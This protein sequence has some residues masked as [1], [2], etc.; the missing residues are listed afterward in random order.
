MSVEHLAYSMFHD[1]FFPPKTGEGNES[2]EFSL[3][4]LRKFTLAQSA[5]LADLTFVVFDFET[6][7]LDSENDKIIEIGALKIQGG[8][9]V[10]EFSYLIN[11]GQPIPQRS[12]YIN[13]ITD[14]M[15]ADAPSLEQVLPDFL[16]FL[17]GGVLVAHNA[18]FDLP[19][20]KRVAREAG[21]ELIWPC[22]CT[23]KMARLLLPDLDSKNLD[24]LAEHFK[25][26]FEARHRSI[27]DC[28]VTLGVL[29]SFLADAAYSL[30]TWQDL[31]PFYAG[32]S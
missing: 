1:V 16:N 17:T 25:L 15:V 23:L 9:V 11:P 29:Q 13:G 5:L 2:L 6:T 21:F 14:E 30:T 19:F 24:R 31:T 26:T 7:G 27:G 3:N 10:E 28:K 20:L 12:T 22:F 18:D 8:A 32:G 4:Q